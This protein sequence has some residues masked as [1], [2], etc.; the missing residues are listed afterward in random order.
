MRSITFVKIC[1]RL[2]LLQ[3]GEQLH[4]DI[5]IL[6]GNKKSSKLIH[7]DFPKIYHKNLTKALRIYI[8]SKITD[9]RL[10]SNNSV[11]RSGDLS[12]LPDLI[13]HNNNIDNE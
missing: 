12:N 10:N 6:L 5:S 9:C 2:W 11:E 4:S 7:K 13:D 8:D 1:L 3:A